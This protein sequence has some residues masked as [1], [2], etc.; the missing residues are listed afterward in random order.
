MI[1]YKKAADGQI[2]GCVPE[3]EYPGQADGGKNLRITEA[4]PFAKSRPGRWRK[5]FGRDLQWKKVPG[6]GRMEQAA[7]AKGRNATGAAGTIILCL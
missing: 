7:A 5:K 1:K 4:Y 6:C 2:E 3:R